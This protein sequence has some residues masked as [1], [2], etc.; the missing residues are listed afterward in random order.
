MV[1]DEC[2]RVVESAGR[3]MGRC[4]TASD[5]SEKSRDGSKS[6]RVV[7]V[8]LAHM[9]YKWCDRYEGTWERESDG[10]CVCVWEGCGFV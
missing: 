10:R 5:E 4:R 9:A 2:R 8:R 7:V 3:W 6:W 1:A